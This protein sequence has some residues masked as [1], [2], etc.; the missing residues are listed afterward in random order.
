M[1]TSKC[2]EI[3]KKSGSFLQYSKKQFTMSTISFDLIVSASS[4][5]RKS[6]LLHHVPPLSVPSAVGG[7]PR[8]AGTRHVFVIETLAARNQAQ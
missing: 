1:V 3:Q 6:R 8:T 7:A 4:S 5:T 2:L